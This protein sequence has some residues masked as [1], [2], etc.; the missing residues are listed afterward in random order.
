MDGTVRIEEVTH[1]EAWVARVHARVDAARLAPALTAGGFDH[2]RLA[3]GGPLRDVL[4]I[5]P[6]LGPTWASRHLA[7]PEVEGAGVR[8]VRGLTGSIHWAVSLRWGPADDAFVG[9]ADGLKWLSLHLAEACGVVT[10][11][12]ACEPDAE[13]APDRVRIRLGEAP[14]PSR[15]DPL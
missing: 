5:S 15:A 11:A 2:R 6:W 13:I 7:R 4:A 8:P 12:F 10:L 3:L 14:P 1:P 9:C